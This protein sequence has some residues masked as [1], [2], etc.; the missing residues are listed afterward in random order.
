[1]PARKSVAAAAA[2]DSSDEDE[3]NVNKVVETKTELD[4]I[5]KERDKKRAQLQAGL[6]K[7]LD[8]LRART[9]QSVAV[10][11][12]E[13]RDTHQQ[14]VDHLLQAIEA[15]DNILRAISEKLAEAQDAGDTL[16]SYLDSAY[17]HRVKRAESFAAMS[18]AAGGSQ[19]GGGRHQDNK[20]ARVEAV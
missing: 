12:Q 1:M 3:I 2:V 11:I 8:D 7:K 20:K 10:H 19:M 17:E 18:A 13:L 6:D 14:R 15:R 5:R 4:K 9:R 16:A